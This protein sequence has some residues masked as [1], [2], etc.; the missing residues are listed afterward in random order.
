MLGLS[1]IFQRGP[2]SWVIWLPLTR[3]NWRRISDK[4]DYG[5]EKNIVSPYSEDDFWAGAYAYVN[6]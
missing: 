4:S 3:E 1:A 2:F 6:A 5:N